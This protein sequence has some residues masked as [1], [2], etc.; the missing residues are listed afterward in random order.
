VTIVTADATTSDAGSYCCDRE[1][2]VVAVADT[3][4]KREMATA[5]RKSRMP[6]R[7]VIALNWSASSGTASGVMVRGCARTPA[8]RN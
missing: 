5:R 7:T 8:G 6:A 1:R 3:K 2:V 4:H